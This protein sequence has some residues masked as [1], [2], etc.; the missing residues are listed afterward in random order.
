MI[1]GIII[2]IVALVFIGK[3]T[4][5]KKQTGFGNMPK[6]SM[7]EYLQNGNSLRGNEYV[8]D[9]KIDGI[10]GGDLGGAYGTAAIGAAVRERL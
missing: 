3:S 10:L 5:S 4:F 6:L 2:A 9:G 8:L 1:G 7:D